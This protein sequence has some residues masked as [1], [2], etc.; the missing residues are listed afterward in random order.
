MPAQLCKRTMDDRHAHR[1]AAVFALPEHFDG[2]R[3]DCVIS[4]HGVSVAPLRFS[5]RTSVAGA[6]P[7]RLLVR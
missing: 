2:D 6:L 1:L 7:A 4:T 5:R 3:F